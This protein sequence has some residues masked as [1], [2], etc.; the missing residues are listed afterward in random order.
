M[1]GEKKSH[2][3][4]AEEKID[5]FESRI[6]P[7]NSSP[8]EIDEYDNYFRMNSTQLEKLNS[9][10]CAVISVRLTQ[11]SL[12]LQR[13]YNRYKSLHDFIKKTIKKTIASKVH[14]Y[15]GRW[16]FQE[17]Q[18]INDNEFALRLAKKLDEVEYKMSRLDHVSLG[19]R[20]LAE[21]FK[22]LQYSKKDRG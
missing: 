16:E 18:A 13:C 1:N 10:Q 15:H 12:Y 11:Y 22:T 14:N 19:I 17:Q 3:E 21:Q 5:D 2:W 20:N 9:T 6:I 8:G 4:L 7:S